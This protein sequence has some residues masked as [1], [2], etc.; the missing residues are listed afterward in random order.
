MKWVN[1]I[2]EYVSINQLKLAKQCSSF[3]QR[4]IQDKIS[5]RH[6]VVVRLNHLFA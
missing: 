3:F 2:Y 4:E 6:F 5:S 1:G